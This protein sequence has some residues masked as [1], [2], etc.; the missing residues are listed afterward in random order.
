MK[1]ILSGVQPSGN[2]HL[3]NYFGAMKHHIEMQ[4]KYESFIFIADYHALTTVRDPEKMKTSTLHLVL[5]YLALG[6][7]PKKTVFFKQS[8]IYEHTQLKW[9]LDCVTPHGLLERAH[10]WKD[11]LEKGKKEPT[12]GLFGYP[13]L[14]AADILLYSPDLVPVGKDQKQHVEIARD[15]AIKFNS[16]FGETFKLPEPYIPE[17]S[18]TIKGT[19]GQ[20]MSK[21]YGNV[22]EIFADDKDLKKQ[23]MSIQTD[24][25]PLEQP[26]DT[27]T[28]NVFYLYTLFASDSEIKDLKNKYESGGFGYGEAKKLLLEKLI[29]FFGPYREKRIELANNLD[30]INKVLKD[31]AQKAK[32]ESEKMMEKVRKAVGYVNNF[33]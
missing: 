9:I 21:S 3:G 30:Y 29:E 11:A 19:D 6:L 28:C 1:R 10:A 33:V 16:I 23:V 8:D 32:E 4:D 17:E 27:N 7:D 2:P 25:T 18:A 14:M 20:K 15:I 26:K 5:D 31:G 24:S 22:I 12:A 13:V